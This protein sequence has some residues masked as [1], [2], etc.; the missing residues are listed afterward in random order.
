MFNFFI[1]LFGGLFYGSKS[2][3]EQAKI[4]EYEKKVAVQEA[5]RNSIKFKICASFQEE[6][7]IKKTNPKW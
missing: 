6:L 7:N 5:Y 1:A 3:H 4:N 2:H